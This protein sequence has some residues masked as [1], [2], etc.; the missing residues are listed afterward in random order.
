MWRVTGD[1]SCVI[2]ENEQSY[3][4]SYDILLDFKSRTAKGPQT[5]I[6][7]TGSRSPERLSASITQNQLLFSPGLGGNPT[8]QAVGHS[9]AC[10]R[11]RPR[12]LS[13]VF[14]TIWGVDDGASRLWAPVSTRGPPVLGNGVNGATDQRMDMSMIQVSTSQI[15]VTAAAEPCVTQYIR[16]PSGILAPYSQPRGEGPH[17]E[18]VLSSSVISEISRLWSPPGRRRRFHK[19]GYPGFGF[20]ARYK[21]GVCARSVI[22]P[23]DFQRSRA[24]HWMLSIALQPQRNS[25]CPRKPPSSL[26]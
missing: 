23:C 19:P 24:Q 10:N 15:S 8:H 18:F 5:L 25:F 1:W 9:L 17:L 20:H 11:E 16:I 2:L 21:R 4:T 14:L 22:H 7:L 26:V 6:L 12:R 13:C 3:L